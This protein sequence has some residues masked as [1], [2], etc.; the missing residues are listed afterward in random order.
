MNVYLVCVP[1]ISN[2]LRFTDSNFNKMCRVA[3]ELSVVQM[4]YALQFSCG[5]PQA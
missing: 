5:F 1:I 4:F 2:L 3:L